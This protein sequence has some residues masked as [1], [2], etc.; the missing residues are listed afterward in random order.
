MKNKIGDKM[1]PWKMHLFIFTS[2]SVSPLDVNPTFQSHIDF[3]HIISHI[4]HI[5]SNL[6]DFEALQNPGMKNHV[7]GFLTVYLGNTQV[8][9]SSFAVFITI[10]TIIS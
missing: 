3:S 8:C 10:L 9:H 5:I 2:L 1:P 6:K 4:A 7:I